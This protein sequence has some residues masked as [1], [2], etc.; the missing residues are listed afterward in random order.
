M[1]ATATVTLA[2]FVFGTTSSTAAPPPSSVAACR[3][4][5]SATLA[6][7]TSARTTSLGFGTSTAARTAAGIGPQRSG[8]DGGEDAVLV[9]LAVDAG[10]GAHGERVE[11]V[12]IGDAAQRLRDGGG[13]HPARGPDPD[14]ERARHDPRG[15]VLDPVGDDDARAAADARAARR[16][17]VPFLQCGG[18]AQRGQREA[19]RVDHLGG[20]VQQRHARRGGVA[21]DGGVELRGQLVEPG[22]ADGVGG[23]R[24]HRLGAEQPGDPARQRVRPALVA[25]AQRDGEPAGLV[26][27]DDPG[28]GALVREQRRD[29]PDRG[30]GGEEEHGAVERAARGRAARRARA[31]DAPSAGG[32]LV[33]GSA[34]GGGDGEQGDHR[35]P[36]SR[37]TGFR[38]ASRTAPSGSGA[39]R[40]AASCTPSTA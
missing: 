33:G 2:P 4:A 40:D 26:D 25:A 39:R 20:A 21:H 1:R 28:V 23:G 27:A 8:R 32:D 19:E 24:H 22:G 14:D 35:V 18:G 16:S 15:G 34:T 37:T 36:Q 31:A 9:G 38:A 3:A 12:R 29:Q 17:R 5:A 10:V 30:A 13:G 6:V 11:T 7:P